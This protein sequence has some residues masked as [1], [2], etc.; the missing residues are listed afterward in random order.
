MCPPCNMCMCPLIKCACVPFNKMCMCPL[1]KFVHGSL[2]LRIYEHTLIYL[3][4]VSP[5]LFI[6]GLKLAKNDLNL[7]ILCNKLKNLHTSMCLFDTPLIF[8]RSEY[9]IFAMIEIL[10]AIH[11]IIFINKRKYLFFSTINLL[12]W[13]LFT[14]SLM[15][16]VVHILCH[17]REI[18]R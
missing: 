3:I 2:L 13:N 4:E 9:L 18:G 14:S 6:W 7:A 8:D 11:W 15:F 12:I 10:L 1:Y 16:V 5:W 17:R